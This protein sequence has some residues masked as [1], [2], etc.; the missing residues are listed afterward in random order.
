MKE[1]DRDVLRASRCSDGV[2]ANASG[3]AQRRE[4]VQTAVNKTRTKLFFLD[5]FLR[6][7]WA[8]ERMYN[9]ANTSAVRLNQFKRT[10][11]CHSQNYI[12]GLLVIRT[13]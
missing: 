13:V 5:L 2:G 3:Q 6:A 8:W 4:K 7:T 10:P 12:T 9:F 1:R 11:I